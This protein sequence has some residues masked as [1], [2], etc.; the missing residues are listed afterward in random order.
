MADFTLEKSTI[1]K[2]DYEGLQLDTRAHDST[3]KDLD[4]TKSRRSPRHGQ[5]EYSDEK[6][7]IT[8]TEAREA[9]GLDDTPESATSTVDLTKPTMI[10]DD[11]GGA[12][13]PKVQRMCGLRRRY[14]WTFFGLVLTI[15]TV[16]A[17]VGGILGAR[18]SA[19]SAPSNSSTPLGSASDT[20]GDSRKEIM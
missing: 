4:T 10:N 17:V 20:P 5:A 19:S 16:A 1:D 11:D 3:E 9:A 6:N 12:P 14:F 8:E 2:C 18:Q 7:F 13:K 15:I